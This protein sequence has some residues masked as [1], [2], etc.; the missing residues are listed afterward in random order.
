M[1]HELDPILEKILTNMR[2]KGKEHIEN[3]R[4]STTKAAKKGS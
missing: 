2:R 3:F 4:Q 1:I